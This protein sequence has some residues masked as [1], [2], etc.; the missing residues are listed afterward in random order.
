MSTGIS[1]AELADLLGVNP[2]IAQTV[3]PVDPSKKDLDLKIIG[4]TPTAA[5]TTN[6]TEDDKGTEEPETEL[7]PFVNGTADVTAEPLSDLD[8]IS[9]QSSQ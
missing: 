1:E 2:S 5:S 6:V 3:L 8:F 7:L 9:S 4:N